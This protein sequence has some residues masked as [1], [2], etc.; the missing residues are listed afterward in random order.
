MLLKVS[1]LNVKGKVGNFLLLCVVCPEIHKKISR[2]MGTCEEKIT[3]IDRSYRDQTLAH[4]IMH[5][6]RNRE[7]RFGLKG[8][9]ENTTP[10][11]I[12]STPISHTYTFSIA[13]S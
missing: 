2:K 13:F 5:G 8:H 7:A 6:R 11:T 9:S 3:S 4:Q 1:P 10:E 12:K